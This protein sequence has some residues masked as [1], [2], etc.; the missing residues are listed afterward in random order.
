MGQ[1]TCRKLHLVRSPL[2]GCRMATDDPN[3]F[4]VVATL[5]ELVPIASI[6]FAFS[7]TGTFSANRRE[8]VTKR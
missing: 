5:L 3:R 7:N 6:L 8:E 4:G 2:D 1:S